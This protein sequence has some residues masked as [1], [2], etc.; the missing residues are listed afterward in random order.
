MFWC[1]FMLS[2]ESQQEDFK[3]NCVFNWG[4]MKLS[5][6]ENFCNIT[7]ANHMT[8]TTSGQVSHDLITLKKR[9]KCEHKV[10]RL[11]RVWLFTFCSVHFNKCICIECKQTFKIYRKNRVSWLNPLN[12]V[13]LLHVCLEIKLILFCIL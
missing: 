3:V 9:G 5:V 4:W 12:M 11:V 10:V 1:Q 8:M 7:H 2:Y 13:I 6:Y